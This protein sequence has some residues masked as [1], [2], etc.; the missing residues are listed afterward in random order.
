MTEVEKK[1]F[2]YAESVNWDYDSIE[3][4]L[5][6]KL[7][8]INDIDLGKGDCTRNFISKF[9]IIIKKIEHCNNQWKL[10]Q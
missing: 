9:K 8:S 2:E 10:N 1:V 5:Y 4:F 6:T 7:D 3:R